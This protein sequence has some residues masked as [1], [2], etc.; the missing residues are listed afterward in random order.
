[1]YRSTRFIAT[2]GLPHHNPLLMQIYADVLGA[3]VGVHPSQTRTRPGSGHP[4]RPGRRERGRRI[5]QL[6]GGDCRHGRRTTRNAARGPC[7]RLCP[8][9]RPT[10]DYNEVYNRYRALAEALPVLK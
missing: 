9:P 10:L 6:V 2:G 1:M 8:T 3:P 5:R 7:E 4:G